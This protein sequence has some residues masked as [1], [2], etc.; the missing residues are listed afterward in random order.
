MQVVPLKLHGCRS[1]G[2]PK[3]VYLLGA[4]DFADEDVPDD[5]FVVYQ[6]R[7]CAIAIARGI[8]ASSVH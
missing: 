3:S 2:P 4:D 7:G 6:V 8:R 1:A 5:A